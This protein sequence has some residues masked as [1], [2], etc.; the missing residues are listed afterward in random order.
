[1]G[2]PGRLSDV[3]FGLVTLLSDY[4]RSGGFVGALHAVLDSLTDG[5]VRTI[6]L[7]HEIPAQD[8]LLGALRL[9][10]MLPYVRPGVHVGVVDPGVGSARLGVAVE[11]GGRV[12][13]GPDNGLLAF[14]LES[15][16]GPTR[17]V[18][19]ENE[20]WF[21]LRRSRTFDGRDVFAPVAAHIALGV[22]VDELGS[23]IDPSS[24]VRLDRPR[25]PV[26]VQVDSFGNVQLALDPVAM[27]VPGT[28]V[29]VRSPSG[30]E[31]EAVLGSTFADVAI[32]DAVLL[33]D[34]DGA[35][36]LSVNQGHAADLLGVRPGDQL[37]LVTDSGDTRVSEPRQGR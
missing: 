19:L 34:S 9:E 23:E 25:G 15:A 27:P 29:A 33:T 31:V 4:G 37:E 22:S 24:L 21:W 8:V 17:A 5:R 20:S 12:F 28:R 11:A 3:R 26:V 6:D 1:M 18:V 36:A 10:R 32:G 7:D 13:V 14:A 30:T 2:R 16:G 35:V